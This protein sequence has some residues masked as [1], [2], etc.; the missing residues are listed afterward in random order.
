M[1]KAEG[2]QQARDCG[3]DQEPETQGGGAPSDDVLAEEIQRAL[4]EA[5]ASIAPDT[6]TGTAGDGDADPMKTEDAGR[7]ANSASEPPIADDAL[8]DALADP[9]GEWYN[10]GEDKVAGKDSG[11]R[12]DKE[13]KKPWRDP[14]TGIPTIFLAED[15]ER[16]SDQEIQHNILALIPVFVIGIILMLGVAVIDPM[17]TFMGDIDESQTQVV[18]ETESEDTEEH[19]QQVQSLLSGRPVVSG[20]LTESASGYYIE[21]IDGNILQF[22]LITDDDREYVVQTCQHD[23]EDKHYTAGRAEGVPNG[24]SFVELEYGE[25][26]WAAVWTGRRFLERANWWE[27]GRRDNG[28]YGVYAEVHMRQEDMDHLLAY[29]K[30]HPDAE[31]SE[32]ECPGRIFDSRLVRN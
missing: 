17:L 4:S 5:I 18:S 11:T 21:P 31:Q 3:E 8:D 6:G 24:V 23:R 30:E 15:D 22:H 7:S 2:Q 9:V 12:E 14:E 32:D 27:P 28:E 16:I 13:G 20:V 10:S 29:Q 19:E 25:E 26:P 1:R